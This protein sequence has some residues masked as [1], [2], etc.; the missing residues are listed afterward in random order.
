MR[1]SP[2][3]LFSLMLWMRERPLYAYMQYFMIEDVYYV[4]ENPH[5]RLE[6]MIMAKKCPATDWLSRNIR[7]GS[8]I[9]PFLKLYVR[10]IL[11]SQEFIP[12]SNKFKLCML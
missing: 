10:E 8:G 1:L 4:V 2:S 11:P 3:Q 9:R 6:L 7:T 5:W 12:V